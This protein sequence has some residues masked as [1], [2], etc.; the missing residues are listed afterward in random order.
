MKL[1]ELKT[2]IPDLSHTFLRNDS[3][4]FVG[5]TDTKVCAINHLVF[6]KTKNYLQEILS[7]KSKA[8]GLWIL[9][10][11]S[12]LDKLD[13]TTLKELEAICDFIGSTE[14][15]MFS[16]CTLSKIFYDFKYSDL[17]NF[18]DGRQMGTCK[19][20]PTALIAQGVFIGEGVEIGENVVIHSG[21][22]IM[23]N[24]II[25]D[26][27]ILYPNVSIYPFVKIGSRV[28]I[29]ANTVIGSDGFGYH[30]HQ[31]KHLKIWHMGSVVIEN[32]VEI[33]SNTS[34]D[35]GTFT[36]TIIGAGSI[37]DNLVQVGHNNRLGKGVVLC[38]GTA[39]AGSCDIGDYVVF[40]GQSGSTE[41]L[42]IGSAVKVA[43]RG[44]VT[45]DLEA[46]VTVAGF[47]ARDIKEW[48]KAN[49]MLRK[50]ALKKE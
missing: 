6:V 42:T 7:Q 38:G 41:G 47:P 33:G 5:L 36:P 20:H 17:N 43:G 10:E 16:M 19:I 15:V 26:Q 48:M 3:I 13:Q 49:A 4:E 45:T 32:D 21:V 11:K 31:G 30:F 1:N 27:T 29:H 12:Y 34:V 25:G 39:L 9:F 40:G 22:T 8:Q 14:N 28:R 35:Q 18:V 2:I 50:L 46:N 37:V 24:A 23:A 44:G